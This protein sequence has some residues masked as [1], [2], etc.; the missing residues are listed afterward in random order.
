MAHI[1]EWHFVI[2]TL[3]L[4]RMRFQLLNARTNNYEVTVVLFLEPKSSEK[5]AL[6]LGCRFNNKNYGKSFGLIRKTT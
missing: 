2:G 6:C 1:L 4:L 5:L 3:S